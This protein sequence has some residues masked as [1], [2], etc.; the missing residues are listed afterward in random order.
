MSVLEIPS[1]GSS[2][3]EDQSFNTEELD[4]LNS[5]F[6]NVLERAESQAVSLRL[7]KH[8]GAARK[9]LIA[10]DEQ[11]QHLRHDVLF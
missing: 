6:S 3:S 2:E 8:F 11:F 9:V 1:R 10:P 4:I 7:L 5:I